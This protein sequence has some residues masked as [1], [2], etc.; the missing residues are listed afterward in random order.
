VTE[1][2][3]GLTDDEVRTSRELYGPNAFTPPPGA[4]FVDVLRR[5]VVRPAI[6]VLVVCG[7]FALVV[8]VASDDHLDAVGVLVGALVLALVDT[9]SQLG[10]RRR[11]AAAEARAR[12]ERVRVVRGGRTVEVD[13]TELVVG[14]VVEI[15]PGDLVP[16]DVRF[17]RGPDIVPADLRWGRGPDLVVNEAHL[18]GESVSAKSVGDT[19][20]GSS[21]VLE[22]SGRA[23]V[24][25]VGDTTEYGRL[26]QG[27]PGDMATATPLQ[28]RLVELRR[29][30]ARL[31]WVAGA[32]VAV[33]VVASGAARDVVDV[34]ADEA[35]LEFVAEA[36]ALGA[37]V[38]V[39]VTPDGLLTTAAV[40][41]AAAVRRMDRRGARVRD[42]A[43]CEALGATTVV[44]ADTTGTLTT[45]DM[46]LQGADFLGS[47]WTAR[48]LG[49]VSG[50]PTSRD[51]F[52]RLAVSLA[53]NSTAELVERDGRTVV[54]GNATEG[55]LLRWIVEQGV[56]YRAIRDR[57]SIAVRRSFDSERGDMMTGVRGPG[58]EMVV[59]VKGAPER[60][61]ER[62]ST[63]LGPGGAPFALGTGRRD[64]I[65]AAARDASARGLRTLA[66]A[67]G[68]T[69]VD[70]E[71]SEL[72]AGLCFDAL[73]LI[74]DP[75]RPDVADDVDR[76]R[77]AG[78]R[79]VMVTGDTK[80][81]A[82]AVA[83]GCGILDDDHDI[84]VEGDVF[85]VSPDD[86]IVPRLG[87]L[88]GLA[89]ARPEDKQRLVKL[90][91]RQGEVVVATGS[92]PRDIPTLLTAD[93]GAA[94][95]TASQVSRDAA[96]VVLAGADL[97][98]LVGG[99]GFG[100]SLFENV[101]KFLQFALTVSPVAVI[102]AFVAAVA[103]Y[104][105]PLTAV[106]ILWVT[107]L[108]GGFAA[109]ALGLDP[110]AED[111]FDTPPP[112]RHDALITPTMSTN[113]LTMGVYMFVVLLLALGTDLLTSTDDERL[114]HTMVFH[115]FVWMQIFNLVNARSVR[116]ERSPFAGLTRS[117]AFLAVLV[118]VMALQTLVIEVG[119][120]VF[121]TVGLTV[122]QHLACVAMGLTAWPVAWLVR[123]LGRERFVA[124]A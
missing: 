3:D 121:D 1:L 73:L 14:D 84:V 58:G 12:R 32:V 34:A 18:T 98:A 49:R 43:A 48:S 103:D 117:P 115:A 30:V 74:A 26:R 89:R 5:S 6:L 90:L 75:L 77:R 40:A 68:H 118:V 52:R 102:V 106:Q 101:R 66:T 59:C 33:A 111:V 65:L 7:V 93:V 31:A 11:I 124:A 86:Y 76:C 94:G 72:E 85:R 37:A 54:E 44:C 79:V 16:A 100:R 35:F 51:A 69:S 22:G 63:M 81:A 53:V 99:V 55:A 25:M 60:V 41:L 56:D 2:A 45:G 123:V 114:R 39:L 112:G 97:G 20:Y 9:V 4:S 67:S 108:V 27:L 70:V 83:T 80:A 104:G 92:T 109:T 120:D 38:V 88:A 64:A 95:G 71:E 23:V 61:L 42:A 8:G 113:I 116:F 105:V 15:G 29:S 122:G 21:R 19:V 107:V 82:T 87:R 62:C 57:A 28:R 17:G 46:L 96:D 110:P 50:Y 119:G 13:S 91:Q 78:V 24:L 36:A 10:T 47:S